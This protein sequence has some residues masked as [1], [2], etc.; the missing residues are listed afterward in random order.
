MDHFI[1]GDRWQNF[2]LPRYRLSPQLIKQQG[3][4]QET[5]EDIQWLVFLCGLQLNRQQCQRREDQLK[6]ITETYSNNNIQELLNCCEGWLFSLHPCFFRLPAVEMHQCCTLLIELNLSHLLHLPEWGKG[7]WVHSS[8][9]AEIWLP[10]WRIN[11][12]IWWVSPFT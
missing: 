1:S 3:L 10:K 4:L 2:S 9:S 12:W 6:P 8:S 11:K 5:A 7:S